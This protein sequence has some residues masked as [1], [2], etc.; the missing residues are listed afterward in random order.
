M[1]GSAELTGSLDVN[2]MISATTVSA[3]LL[4]LS[5]LIT[6]TGTIS[7]TD[8]LEAPQ[9]TGS[10]GLLIQKS[11][12]E[13]T[14]TAGTS[15]LAIFQ[16]NDN[17]QDASIAIV[18]ADSKKSQLHF[19]KHDDIDVGGI[20]YFHEDDSTAPDVMRF[21]TRGANIAS[22]WRGVAG[23]QAYFGVGS[24]ISSGELPTDYFTAQ[25][26][27]SGGGLLLSSSNGTGIIIDR[28]AN[29]G[30]GT[31]KFK[32]DGLHIWTLG[33]ITG[34]NDDNFYIYNS[35]NLDDKSISLI[36]GSNSTKFHTNVTASG[37]I[38]SSGKIIGNSIEVEGKT[39]VTYS[40][41]SIIFGQTNKTSTVRGSSLVLGVDATQHI[42]ASGNISASGRVITNEV[43][44]APLTNDYIRNFNN[45]IQIKSSTESISLAGNVT[46][47]ANISASGGIAATSFTGS[48]LGNV[49]GDSTGLTGTPN[50]AIS[51]LS[52]DIINDPGDNAIIEVESTGISLTGHITASGNISSSGELFAKSYTP[53]VQALTSAG[54]AAGTATNILHS[55]GATVFATVGGAAQGFRLQ[56]LNGIAKGATITIHNVTATAVRIY[57]PSGGKILPLG[58]DAFATL[59]ANQ[60]IQV[61]AFSN[62]EYV[63]FTGN[64]IT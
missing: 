5:N 54:A 22:L 20:R 51:E 17:D 26:T 28:G 59:A 24:D 37:N 45:Q 18:A 64:V 61:T 38:S 23:N 46:A 53:Q 43:Y 47:S 21:R 36:S 19:G 11:L 6:A 10:K 33:N 40:D 48:L 31:I 56:A 9:I 12:G 52:V 30:L 39:A 1:T 41:P 60:T 63:G 7:S 13:G 49:K 29:T 15:N 55:N 57:P 3:S 27:L 32:T 58:E 4:V 2:E 35:A 8:N 34:E 42:T 44:F 50:I 16:N 14:P 62:T 25:G